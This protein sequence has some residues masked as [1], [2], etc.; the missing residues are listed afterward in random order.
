MSRARYYLV[1]VSSQSIFI[2][3]TKLSM[4][5]V[6]N[7]KRQ[8]SSG[9]LSSRPSQISPEIRRD[10]GTTLHRQ[11]RSSSPQPTA[12][13]R[14]EQA[15]K[16]R[17][18]L[19][20]SRQGQRYGSADAIERRSNPVTS[21]K[22]RSPNIRGMSADAAERWSN[23]ANSRKQPPNLRGMS[24][25]A[26]ETWSN[27]VENREA[28]LGSNRRPTPHQP[29]SKVS[30]A[31]TPKIAK[32]SDSDPNQT[33][34]WFT[35]SWNTASDW[36][37]RNSQTI[38]NVGHT[39]LDGAGFLPVVGA[40]ADVVNGVWY[41]AEGKETDAAFSFGAAV[42]GVGDAFAAA[43]GVNR[44]T[45][46]ASVVGRAT[47]VAGVAEGGINS[48]Q[49]GR[50]GD[51]RSAGLAASSAIFGGVNTPRVPRRPGTVANISGDA[52]DAA[53][54]VIRNVA[55]APSTLHLKGLKPALGERT[56]NG[57]VDRMVENA[58][59]EITSFRPSGKLVN[60]A[61]HSGTHYIGNSEA[62]HF[63]MPYRDVAPDG[64]VRE[65]ISGR[66]GQ[67][68]PAENRHVAE[69]YK[70]LDTGRWKTKGHR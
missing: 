18:G 38:S 6:G 27:P 56:I 69:L 2:K 23:P 17:R 65:G 1:T 36:M 43:R 39:I 20:P 13:Q 21:R 25:D 37:Q 35:H 50:E 48:V 7:N 11:N 63:H 64:T 24:A 28:R 66:K 45:R 42:P 49:Y 44:L 16:N 14:E 62:A 40:A 68:V 60:R 53:Y 59:G 51:W 61:G 9:G 57:Y 41:A 10:R 4:L 5:D 12:A 26:A 55:P 54:D 15:L 70:A 67:V 3:N 30:R 46:A 33:G 58:G 19:Q 31:P 8:G 32:R 29:P 47:N 34:N 52:G 22:E